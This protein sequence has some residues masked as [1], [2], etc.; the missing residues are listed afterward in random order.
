MLSR[1]PEL[2]SKRLR[3]VITCSVLLFCAGTLPGQTGTAQ[4]SPAPKAVVRPN[5]SVSPAKSPVL[6]LRSDAD[7]KY[8]IDGVS[9]GELNSGVIKTIPVDFGEHLFE[10]FAKD[11][12][13]KWETVIDIEKP[14]QKVLLIGLAKVRVAR[15]AALQEAEQ[16]RQEI[17]AKQQKA[18]QLETERKTLAGRQMESEEKRVADLKAKQEAQ[19]V[20]IAKRKEILAQIESLQLQMRSENDL[21]VQDEQ[22]A[23]AGYRGSGGAPDNSKLGQFVGVLGAANKT[24]ADAKMQSADGHRRKARELQNQIEDKQRELAHLEQQ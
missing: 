12:I 3:R 21:A 8:S 18:G 7:C 5:P 11:G 15:L 20:L 19:A 9:V 4:T 10:A 14:L 16:L 6:L 1:F 24:L 23:A 22:A 2:V 13:D 17:Q